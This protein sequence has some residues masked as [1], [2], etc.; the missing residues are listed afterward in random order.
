[1]SA[2][3]ILYCYSIKQISSNRIVTVYEY[4]IPLHNLEDRKKGKWETWM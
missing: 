1:M 2:K 3:L 4:Y